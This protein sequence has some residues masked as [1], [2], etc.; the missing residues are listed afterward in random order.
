VAAA[1]RQTVPLKTGA[2]NKK[3]INFDETDPSKKLDDDGVST[4]YLL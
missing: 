1:E 3:K 2:K 4:T